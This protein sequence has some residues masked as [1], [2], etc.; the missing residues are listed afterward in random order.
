MCR[1]QEGD[2]NALATM[3]DRHRGR[4]GEMVK[5]RLD[6]R[7][8]RSIDPPDVLQEA[9]ADAAR[10]LPEYAANPMMPMSRRLGRGNPL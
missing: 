4:L 6:S 3:F 7:L 10:R 2:Q 5:L 1:I 9:F 8:Q